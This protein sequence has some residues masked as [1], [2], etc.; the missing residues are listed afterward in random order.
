MRYMWLFIC[1]EKFGESGQWN[2]KKT[3]EK[4]NFVYYQRYNGGREERGGTGRKIVNF[5]D[6]LPPYSIVRYREPDG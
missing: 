6:G 5:Q 3:S 4:V 1:N 2:L